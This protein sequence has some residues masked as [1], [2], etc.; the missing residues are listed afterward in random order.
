MENKEIPDLGTYDQSKALGTNF[1]KCINSLKVR[2]EFLMDRLVEDIELLE[3]CHDNLSA[4]RQ[5]VLHNRFGK[6]NTYAKGTKRE[7][8]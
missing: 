7:E 3:D 2:M 4:I 8:H 6:R 1:D 5:A